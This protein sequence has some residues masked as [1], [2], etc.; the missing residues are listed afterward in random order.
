M[1]NN[2]KY[3][4]TLMNINKKR[5]NWIPLIVL[6]GVANATQTISFHCIVFQ[7]CL[8]EKIL[9]NHQT[10][11]MLKWTMNIELF[12]TKNIEIFMNME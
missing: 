9:S 4:S 8:R 7:H 6:I 3:I 1:I 2:V 12:W 11:E 10:L 5:R